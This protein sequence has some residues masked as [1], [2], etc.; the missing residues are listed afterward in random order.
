M[1]VQ[2]ASVLTL[3]DWHINGV[4]IQRASSGFRAHS[5][6]A[7]EGPASLARPGRSADLTLTDFQ[8]GSVSCDAKV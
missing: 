1:S 2:L 3:L 4:T 8:R 7:R 6:F 5:S